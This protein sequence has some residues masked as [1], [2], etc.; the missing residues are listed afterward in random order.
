ML[1]LSFFAVLGD[2]TLFMLGLKLISDNVSKIVGERLSNIIYKS[3]LNPLSAIGLGS[4]VTAVFQSAVATNMV[5]IS[6][7]ETGIVSFMGACAV[8]IGTNV[9]TTITAQLVSLSFGQFDITALG[10]LFLFLG[11]LLSL[12]KRQRLSHFGSVVM[13]FGLVFVGIKFLTSEIETLYVYPWFRNIFLIKSPAILLLNGFFITAICQ[14]SSVVST[15]LVILSHAGLITLDSA[16]YLLLGANVGTCIAVMVFCRNKSVVS[17][18]VAVF[19]LLFNIVGAILFI[20]VMMFF[21]GQ[22]LSLFAGVSSTGRA[23]ANFHTFFNIISGLVIIPILSPLARLSQFLV[24]G[25]LGKPQKHK[26]KCT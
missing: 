23:V 11:F 24:N 14:S 16:I 3:T 10:A 21:K 7:V 2:L 22:I 8:V 13:G 25:K 17:R 12:S 15:M 26:V 4:L 20:I 9:G 5:L 1:I 6:L 19:N 18:Q